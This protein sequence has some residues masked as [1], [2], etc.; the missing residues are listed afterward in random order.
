MARWH[1]IPILAA[2]A[3]D[4]GTDS[5]PVAA[6]A[7][8]R[9][10]NSVPLVWPTRATHRKLNHPPCFPPIYKPK[11]VS[12][13]PTTIKLLDVRVVLQFEV[14]PGSNS[15]FQKQKPPG[16]YSFRTITGGP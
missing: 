6:A 12:N 10:A 16:W 3:L 11:A 14:P 1:P 4:Y 13:L 8:L 15:R 5:R 2:P 9:P 7:I